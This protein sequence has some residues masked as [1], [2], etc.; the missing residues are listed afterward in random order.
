[1]HGAQT[2]DDEKIITRLSD[3]MAERRDDGSGWVTMDL[4]R[5]CHDISVGDITR[6]NRAAA[7]RVAGNNQ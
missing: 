1:M 2:S 5:Y 6:L 4:I 3:F 7:R